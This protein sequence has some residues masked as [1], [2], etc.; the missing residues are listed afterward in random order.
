MARHSGKN[1]KVKLGA[2]FVAGVV[3]WDVEEK[4][5]TTDLTAMLDAWKDHDTTL[6]EWSGSVTLRLDHDA[7]AMQTLRAGDVVAV[8]LYSEGD[9]TGKTFFSGSATIESHGIDASFDG[10]VSRKYSIMGKGAL[11]IETV[12]A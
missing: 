7:A 6:K 8:E 4:V 3:S 1:G 5:S 10:E 12:G 2:D 9:A 11:S